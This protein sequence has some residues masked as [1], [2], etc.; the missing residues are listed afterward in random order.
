MIGVLGSF[1]ICHTQTHIVAFVICMLIF[2]L[3]EHIDEI[4]VNLYFA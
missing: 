4:T 2:A 3:Y 1:G